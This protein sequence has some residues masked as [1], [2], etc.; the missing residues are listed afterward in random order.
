MTKK[1]FELSLK[2]KGAILYYARKKY[3]KNLMN[4]S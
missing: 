4:S 3:Q 1:Y 2:I